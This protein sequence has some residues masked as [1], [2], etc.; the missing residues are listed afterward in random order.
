MGIT[1]RR[2][3]AAVALVA[4]AAL[5]MS[6]CLAGGGDDEGD[7]ANEVLVW[8]SMDPPVIEGL[9]AAL[10]ARAEDEGI[11]VRVEAVEDINSLIMQRIQAGDT[12]DIA[13]IP[14]PGVVEDVVARA[15]PR[16]R[17]TT[18]STWRPSRRR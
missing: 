13:M 1:K 14:Q 5:T 10:D 16:S 9:Q 4:T 18:C 8:A 12:P 11:T 3:G 7:E 17:S 15:E 6:G 2:R